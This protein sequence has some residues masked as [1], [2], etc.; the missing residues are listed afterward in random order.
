MNNC[1]P[2]YT[3]RSPFTHTILK[4]RALR[5]V[6]HSPAVLLKASIRAEQAVMIAE[7]KAKLVELEQ[8]KKRCAAERLKLGRTTSISSQWRS[9]RGSRRSRQRQLCRGPCDFCHPR[10][11]R[12][13]HAHRGRGEDKIRRSRW[14][15]ALLF[16]AVKQKFIGVEDNM[17]T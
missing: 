13:A 1:E 17:T 11:R 15:A 3:P 14:T 7:M 4:I 2:P 6:V 10:G 12:Q 5:S 8:D 16:A 9:Q